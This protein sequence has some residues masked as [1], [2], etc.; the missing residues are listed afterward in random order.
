MTPPKPWPR[1]AVIVVC[2]TPESAIIE[3][4]SSIVPTLCRD[5]RCPLVADGR[6]LETA[7]LIDGS[8][9]RPI[10]CLCLRCYQTYEH[11]FDLLVDHRG[12]AS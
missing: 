9:R 1:D 12:G 3:R 8:R 11:V 10:E 4:M 7:R 6:T 2:A 5:C